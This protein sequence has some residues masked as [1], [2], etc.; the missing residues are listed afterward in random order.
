MGEIE[1]G[2]ARECTPYNSMVM[3]IY[4]NKYIDHMEYSFP[5]ACSL[6]QYCTYMYIHLR[7]FKSEHG[8]YR[9]NC[10]KLIGSILFLLKQTFLRLL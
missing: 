4:V 10:S 1:G 7:W 9:Q 8:R 5:L 6:L 3:S 2:S